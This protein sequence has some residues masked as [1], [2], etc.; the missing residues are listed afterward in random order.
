MP[1]DPIEK[2]LE[3]VL[4]YADLAPEDER[5]VSAELNEHLHALI[6]STPLP[7]PKEN[8]TPKEIYTM[9]KD[10]FGLPKKVGR[11]I[12][13]AKGRVRTYFKKQWR[14]L[15][16][17]V[18][19]AFALAFVVRLTVAQAF[20]VSGDGVA[21]LIPRGSRVLVYKLANSFAPGDVVVYRNS[22]NENLLGKVVRETDTGGWIVQ[23]Y[24]GANCVTLEITKSQ[25]VGRVFLNTR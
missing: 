25:I 13:I 20:Y 6:E 7:N 22:Q 24:S 21:P 3:D 8:Y 15:P 16:W 19:I 17:K 1:R 4:C 23:R 2:Y 11:G 18:A 10:Q 14:K 12:A 9:L 5:T